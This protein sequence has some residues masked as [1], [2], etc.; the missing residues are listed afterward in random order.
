MANNYLQINLKIISL[1]GNLLREVDPGLRS[2]KSIEKLTISNN[3]LECES[4]V[5][6]LNE[7]LIT[8]IE[9]NPFCSMNRGGISRNEPSLRRTL[10][11]RG[12]LLTSKNRRSLEWDS[13]MMELKFDDYNQYTETQ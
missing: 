4:E 11:V 12:Q 3:S 8:C 1:D 2:M 10:S 6:K 5:V 13:C 9:G 7:F